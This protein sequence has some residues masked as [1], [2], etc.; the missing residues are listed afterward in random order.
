MLNK[1]QMRVHKLKLKG[2]FIVL[3][4]LII[5]FLVYFLKKESVSKN[6][7]CGDCNIIL[8]D[9]DCLRADH[10]GCY[11]YP[12]NATP[13][14]DEF[15]KDSM[16]FKNFFIEGSMTTL[17]KM[18]VYSSLYP[19]VHGI[20]PQI[21]NNNKNSGEGLNKKFIMLPQILNKDGYSTVLV[22]PLNSRL[23]PLN[24]GFGRGFK[25]FFQSGGKQNWDWGEGLEWI[26]DNKDRKFFVSFYSS[27]AHDPY[28]PSEENLHKFT[29]KTDIK[30]L[31]VNELDD[32][33]IEKIINDPSIVFKDEVIKEN[34]ELFLNKK[35]LEE[36][37]DILCADYSIQHQSCSEFVGSMFWKMFNPNNSSDLELLT[38]FYDS[39][40]YDEDQHFSSIIETLKHE[41]LLNK[42]I[43]IFYSDHGEEFGEHGLYDHGAHIYDEIV[44]VP[45]ILFIPRMGGKEINALAQG[46]DIMPTILDLVGIKTP[47]H[48]QGKSLL[49]VILGTK[50]S[51]RDYAFSQT[52]SN[53]FSIRSKEW[54]Y[55]TNFV[56]DE[57]LYNLKQDPSEKENLVSMESNISS[58][59]REKLEEHL[60][61]FENKEMN[62]KKLNI[63]IF[64]KVLIILIF[65]LIIIV[66]LPTKYFKIKLRM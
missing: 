21:R 50:E 63:S 2:L 32:I 31:S 64:K 29:N 20:K 24:L 26:K 16:L 10:F 36:S 30:T 42:T 3:I 34:P 13:H 43:I 66:I 7:I 4:I 65:L 59:M 51:V 5:I 18:S 45:L 60:K 39:M 22:G 9:I 46:V 53:F 15:A 11:G 49:P 57:E 44:H 56:G 35:V 41:G 54:K 8:I 58:E 40:V 33:A 47:K 52:V 23:T 62:K 25:Y 6:I 61:A 19:Y 55:I 1:I 48:V 14:I 27:R 17:S 37:L 28:T 12:K 38:A